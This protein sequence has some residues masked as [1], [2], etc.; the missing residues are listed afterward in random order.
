M[1]DKKAQHTKAPWSVEP[2]LTFPKFGHDWAIIRDSQD[3]WVA[4][5]TID[6]SG[7]GG[8]I[9]TDEQA[10]NARLIAAAPDLLEI[11][12][13][14]LDWFEREYNDNDEPTEARRLRAVIAKAK[15]ESQ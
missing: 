14:I 15:G 11:A 6:S 4:L 9:T 12:H 10:A 2:T 8:H 13:D 5:A 3:R 1:S 7:Y